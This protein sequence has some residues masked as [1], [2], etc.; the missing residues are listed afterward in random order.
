VRQLIG[1]GVT[2]LGKANYADKLGEYYS[3]FFGLSVGLE[4][5]CKL[6][7]VADYAIMNNGRMPPEAIVRSYGHK[8]VDLLNVAD[9]VASKLS[10][11]RRYP[12]QKTKIGNKI[13]ECLDAFADAS[14]GRYANFAALGDPNLGQSE[15]IRKWWG[16]VAELILKEYY[17]NKPVQIRVE[18]RANIVDVLMSPVSSVLHI[19]EAGEVMDDVRTSSIRSGQAN[20]VQRHSRYYVLVEV[21]WL[22]DV[23]SEL[24]EIACYQYNVGA[25]FGV[26]EYFQTYTV[27]D[28]FLKTRKNWPLN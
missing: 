6:I 4:R 7:L 3:A 19:N 24:S 20:L 9:S 14:R 8:L 28:Q 11:K 22:S 18:G 15:P 25:F 5:L 17:Y 21:R 27:D 16:D 13:I 26:N 1:S 10:L 12:R 2:A 23:F